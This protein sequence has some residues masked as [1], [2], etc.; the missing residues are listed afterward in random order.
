[1]CKLSLSPTLATIPLQAYQVNPEYPST[2]ITHS[3]KIPQKN[4]TN[5]KNIP[6]FAPNKVGTQPNTYY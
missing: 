2:K 1:M 6:T 5:S 4:F 3:K